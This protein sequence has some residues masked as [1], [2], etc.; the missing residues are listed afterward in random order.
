M[1][2]K[3]ITIAISSCLLG[4]NVRYDGK[5]KKAD[6]LIEQLEKI[7]VL[8]PICPEVEIGMPVPREKLHLI[9]QSENLIMV[10]EKS[11]KDWTEAMRE[12]GNKRILKNDFKEISGIILKSKSPSCGLKT[13]KV[14]ENGNLVSEQGDGLFA[15][16]VLKLYPALPITDELLLRD[17]QLFEKFINCVN[18][19]ADSR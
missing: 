15:S 3:K 19:Y 11:G 2:S 12:F 1:D 7:A 4:Q 14:Y 6:S 10:A 5:R 13:T 9:R 18:E 17:S 8:L 16:S